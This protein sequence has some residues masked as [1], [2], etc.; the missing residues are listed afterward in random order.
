MISG[1]TGRHGR[2]SSVDRAAGPTQ[3]R[4]I[5]F[6]LTRTN[7]MNTGARLLVFA[8]F[9]AACGGG[10]GETPDEHARSISKNRA[11][12]EVW[13]RRHP[14]RLLASNADDESQE[15]FE[16]CR[17][18]HS[19]IIKS[20]FVLNAVLR[21]QEVTGLK[22]VID[23]TDPLKFL[24]E[25]LEVDFSEPEFMR[26]SFIGRRSKETATIVNAVVTEYL[27]ETANSEHNVRSHR[28]QELDKARQDVDEQVRTKR[29][30]LERLTKALQSRHS[31]VLTEQQKFTRELCDRLRQEGVE[32]TLD[33]LRDKARLTALEESDAPATDAPP[34]SKAAIDRELEH[35]GVIVAYTARKGILQE[36]I[37]QSANPET[38]D[39]LRELDSFRRELTALEKALS[40]RTNALNPQIAE[41]LRAHAIRTRD[42]QMAELK[43]AI[44]THEKTLKQMQDHL[45]QQKVEVEQGNGWFYDVEGLK[46]DLEQ[47]NKLYRRISEE[48]ALLRLEQNAQSR[49][50][51][52]RSA[53]A[54]P[55]T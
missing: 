40:T 19:K 50:I 21:N 35:D 37:A 15:D 34:A 32:I 13:I 44:R 48:I 47:S 43:T 24:E 17:R 41:R 10:C 36:L 27:N 2:H 16:D 4:N 28:L 39:A 54:E 6:T 49:V 55:E 53:Q 52:H 29:H 20:P 38:D 30:N 1:N 25:R 12:A 5:S 3:P 8:L 9:G 23:A 18:A 31:V 11:F 26:I 33:L 42:T 46:E 7:G 22:I 14:P 51:L 45:F